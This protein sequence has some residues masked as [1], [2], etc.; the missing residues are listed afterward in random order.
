M[1]LKFAIKKFIPDSIYLEYMNLKIMGKWL[2]LCNPKT[3]NEKLQWLKLHDHNPRYINMVDK[4]EA[5]ELVSEIIGSEY[6]VPTLGVWESFDEIDFDSLPEKFVLKTTHDSGGVHICKD[7]D[8][9]DFESAKAIFNSNLHR[10]FYYISREWPYRNVKPRIIAEEYLEDINDP[11]LKDYKVYTFNGKAKIIFIASERSLGKTKAD[12]FDRN[13]NYLDFVWGYPHANVRP[14]KPT[15]FEKMCEFAEELSKNTYT[16]RVDFYE[17][18]GKL[19]F[20]ELTFYDGSGFAKIDPIE[21]DYKLGSW[22]KLPYE[23]VTK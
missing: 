9:F 23:D 3:Y 6:I 18:K 4:Y 22:V 11:N 20:G 17:V 10:N 21:W 16:L 8:N 5:K 7:K 1:D 15:N 2:N 13:F 12:Y 19:Y 14:Q